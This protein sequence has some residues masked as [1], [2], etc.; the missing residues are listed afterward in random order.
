MNNIAYMVIIANNA[1]IKRLIEQSHA[2]EPIV[3]H[4]AASIQLFIQSE[5]LFPDI[6]L[7]DAETCRSNVSAEIK[8]LQAIG[9]AGPIILISP[10]KLSYPLP[11]V[12]L[13]RPFRLNELRDL[14]E[15][16]LSKVAPLR[17][18]SERVRDDLTEKEAAI[19]NRLLQ[20]AGRSVQKSKLLQEIWGYGPEISTRT[21]ETHIHRLRR[22]IDADTTHEWSLTT[23]DDGYQLVKKKR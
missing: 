21:L 11:I 2:F 7:L 13:R 10:E 6:I 16:C 14:I 9:Y 1:L 22:K 15:F 20:D 12:Q 8:S 18:P 3:L 17:Q 5:D 23:S 19:F 4:S